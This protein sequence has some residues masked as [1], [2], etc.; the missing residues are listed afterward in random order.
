MPII[1]CLML[2]ACVLP[3]KAQD[4]EMW[5]RMNRP[6]EPFRIIGNIYYVG[7]SDVACYLITTPE[8]HI[9]IDGGFEETVPIILDRLDA[10]S[11]HWSGNGRRTTRKTRPAAQFRY[12]VFAAAASAGT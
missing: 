5:R 11:R 3:A 6:A 2:I 12:G 1:P 7:A 4:N 9:L 8:G 10:S